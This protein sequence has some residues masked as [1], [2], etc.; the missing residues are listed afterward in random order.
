MRV[1]K[2]VN[3][4][5][6]KDD[7]YVAYEENDAIFELSKELDKDLLELNEGPDAPNSCACCSKLHAKMKHW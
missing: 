1:S 3:E 5:R 4:I 6:V 7:I 2:R